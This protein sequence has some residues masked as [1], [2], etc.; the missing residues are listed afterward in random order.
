MKMRI[1]HHIHIRHIMLNHFEKGWNAAQSFRDLNELLGEEKAKLKD[2]TPHC[3][4]T[5]DAFQYSFGWKIWWNANLLSF[6]FFEEKP[7]FIS[8]DEI[9]QE[10]SLIV[11]LQQV[12]LC[13]SSWRTH[14]ANFHTFPSILRRFTMVEWST[15]KSLA[16]IL[17][18]KL[19][20]SSIKSKSAWS[21]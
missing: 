17:D 13:C 18:V 12:R 16:N 11:F 20:S 3:L 2:G 21:S 14:P 1:E 7:W 8:R 15:L 6:D 5:L 4:L 10:R 9:F 19:S